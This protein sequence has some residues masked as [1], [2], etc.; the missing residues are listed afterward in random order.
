MRGPWDRG[1]EIGGRGTPEGELFSSKGFPGKWSGNGIFKDRFNGKAGR[2]AG[3]AG[4]GTAEVE[5]EQ[6]NELTGADRFVRAAMEIAGPIE[7][8]DDEGRQRQQ[9]SKQKAIGVVV[10][11]VFQPL[12]GLA[13]VET[14]VLDFPAALGHAV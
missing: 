13:A 4:N 7:P 1:V 12:V 14:L 3:F 9:P 8:A 2:L 10:T 5:P 6:P 11:D